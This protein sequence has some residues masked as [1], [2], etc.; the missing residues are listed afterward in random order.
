METALEWKDTQTADAIASAV[1]RRRSATAV[2][3][4]SVRPDG[5]PHLIPL[6][7]AWDGDDLVVLSK[8]NAQKVRNLRRDPRVV[9]ALGSVRDGMDVDLIEGLGE[10]LEAP[11][12][13]V[14]S[15]AA[16]ARYAVPMARLGLT[17]DTFFATYSQP[18]R[19]RLTRR[20]NWG[21]PGWA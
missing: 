17:L 11:S 3:I 15:A 21:Q 9:L 14:V 19:I 20:L 2:W 5:A 12:E 7:F 6:W 13:S 8:P 16:F 1:D 4:A 18:I 10:V